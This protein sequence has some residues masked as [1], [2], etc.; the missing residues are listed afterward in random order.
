MS[1]AKDWAALESLPFE[2]ALRKL[3]ETVQILERGDVPLEQAID[4]FEEGMRL[5]HVCG[6]KLKRAEQQVEMLVK[7]NEE[8]VRE[9]FDPEEAAD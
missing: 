9:P 2:E 7:R 1:E 4:L 3:E 5:A 8:W 6:R